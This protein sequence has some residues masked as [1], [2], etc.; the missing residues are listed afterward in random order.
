MKNIDI[1]HSLI[2][3]WYAFTDWL[4]NMIRPDVDTQAELTAALTDR[5]FATMAAHY[6]DVVEAQQLQHLDE[7]ENQKVTMQN[8]FDTLAVASHT[9]TQAMVACAQDVKATADANVADCQA[10]IEALTAKLLASQRMSAEMA[11]AIALVAVPAPEADPAA[12]APQ[13]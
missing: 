5:G 11:E 6:D 13:A 7:L 8:A 10:Q 4:I 2:M 3:V 9:S 12:P 1:K